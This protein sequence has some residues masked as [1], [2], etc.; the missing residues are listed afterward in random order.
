MPKIS[1]TKVQ[2]MVAKGVT[3][4]MGKKLADMPLER[5]VDLAH[6]FIGAAGMP[7]IRKELLGDAGLCLDIQDMLKAGK[8]PE[9]VKS[10]YWGCQYWRDFW[11]KTLELEEGM[12]DLIIEQEV[13]KKGGTND[14]VR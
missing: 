14:R 12:L 13:I 4:V 3:K 1:M 9:E 7:T 10:F 5:Q 11:E 6:K 2:T 8:P